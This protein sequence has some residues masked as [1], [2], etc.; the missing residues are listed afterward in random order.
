MRATTALVLVALSGPALGEPTLVA[1]Q[2]PPDLAVH[3]GWE[4]RNEI[5]PVVVMSE[6]QAKHVAGKLQG[7]E[8]QVAEE[9]VDWRVWLGVGLLVGFGG[10]YLTAKALR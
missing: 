3:A 8:D 10:G 6:A 9:G 5:T 4:Y 1:D 2:P 7:C